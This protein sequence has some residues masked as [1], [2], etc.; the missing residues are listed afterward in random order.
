[1]SIL[2]LRDNNEFRHLFYGPDPIIVMDRYQETKPDACPHSTHRLIRHVQRVY[3]H[4]E[5]SNAREV[6][7]SRPMAAVLKGTKPESPLTA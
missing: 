2:A 1:V 6:P 3:E 5:K 7:S 4:I